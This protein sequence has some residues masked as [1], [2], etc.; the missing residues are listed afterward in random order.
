MS[1][2]NEYDSKFYNFEND[3]A[4]KSAKEIVPI[5]LELLDV[6]SVIDVGCGTGSWLTQLKQFGIVD[7][8]G[9]DGEWA[10]NERLLIPKG[11][12][13]VNDLTKP[14]LLNRKFDLVICLEVAEHIP[15][16]RAETL[17]ESLVGLGPAILF[18]AAIPFQGGTHHVNE[19]WPNYW[20]KL[21][22]KKHYVTIDCIRKKVWSNNN[23]A[24][25][26]AQNMLMF[27]E[28]NLLT[29]N[30]ALS[31]EFQIT[32]VSQ[33]SIVHPSYWLERNS[34]PSIRQLDKRLIRLFDRIFHN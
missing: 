12:F 20:A 33:L 16:C 10:N 7:I 24:P 17:V 28:K 25:F 19:Q 22:F 6:K 32:N 31:Q 23:V 1:K 34:F 27:V 5:I 8:T 11:N 2:T 13:I 30:S 26:Y 9:V 29:K 15:R 21:F 18:S 3:C 4:Q 14:L